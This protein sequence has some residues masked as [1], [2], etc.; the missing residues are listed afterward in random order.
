MIVVLTLMK[1]HG[2]MSKTAKNHTDKHLIFSIE[3]DPSTDAVMDWF[4]YYDELVERKNTIDTAKE[5]NTIR[6][7]EP[8][9]NYASIWYRKVL[10]VSKREWIRSNDLSAPV[11]EKHRASFNATIKDE[12]QIINDFYYTN[13][14]SEKVLCDYYNIDVNKLTTLKLASKLD[15]DIPD[16]IVCTSKK[17]LRLFIKNHSKGIINKSIDNHLFFD[18]AIDHERQSMANYTE[19]ITN[20]ILEKLPNEFRPSLFQEKL[21]KEYEIRSFYL[22]GSFYSMAIFSQNNEKTNVDFRR[23][24][25]EKPNRKV[26]YKL[27]KNVE[28]NL[29]KLMKSL[30]LNTGSIDIVKTIDGRFVFL[31]VNPAGQYGMTSYPCNYYLEKEIAEFLIKV[32]K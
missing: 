10:G 12:A 28:A 15:I 27:P 19:E 29:D 21:A 2:I 26:S 23:Y 20:E 25:K 31:E 24:D 4:H 30:H 18:V 9:L 1:I 7:K 32:R 6:L 13:F 11:F 16:T 8:A 14:T 17:E 5:Q 22:D 3:T